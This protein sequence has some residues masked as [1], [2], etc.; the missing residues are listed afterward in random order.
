MHC[1]AAQ[2]RPVG[3]EARPEDDLTG[4]GQGQASKTGS[5]RRRAGA[6]CRRGRATGGMRQRDGLHPLQVRQHSQSDPWDREAGRKR[7]GN[8]SVTVC[9]CRAGEAGRTAPGA[10]RGWISVNTVLWIWCALCEPPAAL[11]HHSRSA[12]CRLVTAH[13]WSLRTSSELKHTELTTR[14]NAAKVCPIAI[15]HSTGGV[16]AA[17]IMGNLIRIFWFQMSAA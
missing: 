13:R 8:A 3:I 11:L 2:S 9:L 6:G 12:H 7:A 15:S 16:C 17:L 5:Q 4:S 10:P 1:A 14:Y